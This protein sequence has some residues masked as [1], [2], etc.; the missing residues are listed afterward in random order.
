MKTAKEFL[1]EAYGNQIQLDEAHLVKT[2]EHYSEE[3]LKEW[4]DRLQ[5]TVDNLPNGFMNRDI[6]KKLINDLV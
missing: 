6:F 5:I 1:R 4:K 3:R 2:M